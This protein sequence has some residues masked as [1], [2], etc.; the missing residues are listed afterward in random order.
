MI[1]QALFIGCIGFL[2]QL[3]DGALGMAYGTVSASILLALGITPANTSAAVHT[4]Q[5]FTCGAAGLSHLYHRN[6]LW[7]L[8]WRLALPGAAGAIIGASLLVRLDQEAIRP[9]I[10]AYLGGLGI[11][12][13][14]RVARRRP[15]QRQKATDRAAFPTGF[16]GGVA[17]SIGG[18]G[19][20]PIAT[21]TLVGRGHEPRHTIGSVS[22][23]EFGVKTVSATT[24]FATLGMTHLEV[25]LPLIIG[26]LIAA[27]LGG[28]LVRV[29]PGKA[30]MLM[31]GLVILALSGW[32]LAKTHF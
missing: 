17:D 8:V 14:Y 6:V 12:I 19:W 23:S 2:A 13:L 20:G 26:G 31:I 29:I 5:I 9:W 18:G 10:S 30:L 28:Y 32:Q 24:F 1:D 11:M 15:A 27:P 16:I 4:A 21:S 22:L 3:V 25:V 7:P